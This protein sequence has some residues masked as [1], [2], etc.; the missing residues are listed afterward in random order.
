MQAFANI[1]DYQYPD[2]LDTQT[3]VIF[4]LCVILMAGAFTSLV[5]AIR[6][7]WVYVVLSLVVGSCCSASLSLPAV[8][9]TTHAVSCWQTSSMAAQAPP[10][11]WR[12]SR[13]ITSSWRRWRQGGSG[14]ETTLSTLLLEL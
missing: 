11:L 12:M 3:I 5:L 10:P 4:T 14:E 13:L 9:S 1:E 2:A 6:Q 8:L 7:R